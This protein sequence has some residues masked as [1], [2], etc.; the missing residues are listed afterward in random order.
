MRFK[1]AE[2][3]LEFAL[4]VAVVVGA[5]IVMQVY[6]KRGLQGKLKSSVDQLGEQYSPG[7]T[8]GFITSDTFSDTVETLVDGTTNISSE[9]SQ[10][11]TSSDEIAGYD[12]EYWGE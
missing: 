4:L 1:I 9:T 10:S 11:M 6:V 7:H 5:L 3:T 8:T 12:E 2:S